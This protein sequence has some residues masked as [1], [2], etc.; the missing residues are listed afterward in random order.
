MRLGS[1]FS[2]VLWVS[3]FLSAKQLKLQ[4]KQQTMPLSICTRSIMWWHQR[5]KL[6][7]EMLR[8]L[9][10]TL[11]EQMTSSSVIQPAGFK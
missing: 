10:S 3:A 8:Q 2:F 9:G 6:I 4:S 7:K 1:L 11:K 5:L